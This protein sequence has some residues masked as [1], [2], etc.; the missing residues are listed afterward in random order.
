MIFDLIEGAFELFIEMLLDKSKKNLNDKYYIMLKFDGERTKNVYTVIFDKVI[1]D[2][3]VIDNNSIF[4]RKDTDD[5]EHSFNQLIS[6]CKFYDD[7]N[8]EILKC[9]NCLVN[10]Y[11]S[12]NSEKVIVMNTYITNEQI[13]EIVVTVLDISSK[14]SDKYIFNSIR[15]VLNFI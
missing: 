15:E 2:K 11:K 1:E 10:K 8:S 12:D 9:F 6:K 4:L 3:K 13:Y 14:K 5:I 7:Y